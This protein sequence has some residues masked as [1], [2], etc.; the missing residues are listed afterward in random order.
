M[1]GILEEEEMATLDLVQ[2]KMRTVAEDYR[3]ITYSYGC[4]GCYGSCDHGCDS[5]CAHAC[6]NECYM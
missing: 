5:G 6:V 3:V 1:F 2:S 4:Y